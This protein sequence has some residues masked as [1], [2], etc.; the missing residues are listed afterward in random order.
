[1][2]SRDQP[3]TPTAD[4]EIAQLR[5]RIAELE[6]TAAARQSTSAEQLLAAAALGMTNTTGRE[7]FDCLAMHLVQSLG[8]DYVVVGRLLPGQDRISTLSMHGPNG[9]EKMVEYDLSGTP[10]ER[11][12]S[13]DICVYPTGVQRSFPTDHMLHEMQ[14]ESYLGIPLRSSTGQVLGLLAVLSTKPLGDVSQI[15]QVLEIFSS[16]AA[17]EVERLKV[18]EQLS[19]ERSRLLMAMQAG[20]V[21]TYEWHL[22]SQELTWSEG[23]TAILGIPG[24]MSLP[25]LVA[26]REH[27][28]QADL[29]RLQ[30]YFSQLREGVVTGGFE[31]RLRSEHD[32]RWLRIQGQVI[33]DEHQRPSRVIGTMI[34]VT[35]DHQF[36]QQQTTFRQRVE[37]LIE[38]QQLILDGMP[39]GCLMN[40]ADCRITYANPAVEAIFGYTSEEL[41][42]NLPFGLLVPERSRAAVEHVLTRLRAG[43]RSTSG[44]DEHTTKA[45]RT[46]FC[47]WRHTPLF[48]IGGE[49][50]GFLSMVLD[51]TERI[52]RDE[53]IR[54]TEQQLRRQLDELEGIYAAAP[55]GLAYF[56]RHGRL[57]RMN[58]LLSQAFGARADRLLGR[59]LE[60][61]LGDN[62]SPMMKPLETVI[63]T[64][65]LL[66]DVPIITRSG[67]GGE[68][69]RH[70]LV[71]YCPVLGNAG[72][73]VG[74]TA[75]VE[76]VTNRA[77]AERERENLIRQ[78]EL[79][80]AELERFAYTVSHDLK[81]PL[82]TISGFAGVL[83]Q[84][85]DMGQ[86]QAAREDLREIKDAAAHMSQLLDELLQLS[87]VGRFVGE[88]RPI[89]LAALVRRVV[90][91]AMGRLG[92]TYVEMKFDPELPTV[93]GDEVRLYELFQNLIDNALKF[94]SSAPI[95][96]ITVGCRQTEP[97]IVV[98]VKDNGIGIQPKYLERI[99]GLFEQLSPAVEGTGVGLA[100]AKRV[101]EVHGG[102][103]WAESEGAGTGT[104][105]VMEFPRRETSAST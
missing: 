104:T 94:A 29:P 33:V 48:S 26:L 88:L 56:D 12:V 103:I 83:D 92:S 66:S 62:T 72:E 34:D 40:D 4:E 58:D 37:R 99:F 45:G 16:R 59:K 61:I 86:L 9:P 71:D 35:R 46:V 22:D 55:V 28:H 8:M 76:D 49:F 24:G 23:A 80:N 39:I 10:C 74:V 5:A 85:L 60:E 96:S 68:Q 102:K 65:E 36:Q 38:T 79:K 25:D 57:L 41:V 43:D 13:Q 100:I 42:G 31:F 30:Q 97:S 82:I 11:V 87:R 75:V 53:Q 50:V 18:A 20:R 47:E 101:M 1:M 3:T 90:S 14:I 63:A 54:R 73:V 52:R 64:G 51:V 84:D 105:I 95:P 44:I 91:A 17:A 7:F 98:F 67:P 70:W 2:T 69:Q 78:L 93:M 89:S 27:V 15:R 6:S 77:R 81:S 19:A 32:Y 21:A